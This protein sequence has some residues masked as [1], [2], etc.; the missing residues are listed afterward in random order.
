MTK[1]YHNPRCSKSRAALQLLKSKGVE[2]EEVRYLDDPP[3]ETELRKV[4]EM[5]GVKPVELV[6]RGEKLFKELG[7]AEKPL[8]DDQWLTTLAANPKLL[9]RPIVLH[10]GRAVVGRPPERVLEILES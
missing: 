1:I 2:F 4:V 9:Q 5:L 7:L 10:R 6:R 3:T 8:S